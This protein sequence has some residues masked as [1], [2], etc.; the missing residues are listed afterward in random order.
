MRGPRIIS[1]ISALLFGILM[2][3]RFN[4]DPRLLA[5]GASGRIFHGGE[6][7]GLVLSGV[8]IGTSITLLCGS[9]RRRD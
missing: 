7:L 9:R 4:G 6:I 2:F 1:A 5:P 8:W 3:I